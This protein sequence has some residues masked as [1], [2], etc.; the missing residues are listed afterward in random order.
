MQGRH[1]QP[2]LFRGGAGDLQVL[3]V[4]LVVG[5]ARAVERREL[6]DHAI[7]APE[8]FQIGDVQQQP[9]VPGA[10]QL[11]ELY[12]ARFEHRTR[13]GVLRLERVDLI[14]DRAQLE[15]D[16]VGVRASPR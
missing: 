7:G 14:A 15:T 13:L 4:A 8:L 11:V 2:A 12:H 9:H 10:P 1:L 16:V 3:E 5:D 6:R